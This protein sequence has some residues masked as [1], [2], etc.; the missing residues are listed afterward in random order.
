[1]VLF[2]FPHVWYKSGHFPG[3]V[4]KI[5]TLDSTYRGVVWYIQ[6]A[7]AGRCPDFALSPKK[8]PM[9]T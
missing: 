8:I 1:M 5:D 4:N 9:H 7:R 3:A 2:D 6:N